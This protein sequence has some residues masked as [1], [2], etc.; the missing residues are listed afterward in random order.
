MGH[1]TTLLE[2]WLVDIET[3]TDLTMESRTKLAQAKS[4]GLT[5]TLIKEAIT[6]GKS[7]EDIKDLL[8]LKI[9]K[10]NIH[11]SICHFME[12]Q[13]KEKESLAVYIHH[14]KREAKRCNFT[15]NTAT[16]RTFVKGFKDSHTLAVRIYEKGP[17]TLTDAIPEVEKLQAPQQLTATLIPS[18]PVNG[19]TNEEDHCFRWQ[20]AG[21]IAQHCPNVRC[22]ECDEYGYLV[23]DC[24]HRIPPSGTPACHCRSPS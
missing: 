23:V 24:P 15:N 4:R 2:D 1:E 7:W 9:C 8:Q 16:I 3:A 20:E 13:Q 17:Q 19:M 21:H 12:I 5:L 11:T 6:S 10:S 22:F 18:S 14:F